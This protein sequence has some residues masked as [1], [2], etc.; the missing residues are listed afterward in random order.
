MT[1][2]RD[3]EERI[4]QVNE[5][6]FS[7]Y[8]LVEKRLHHLHHDLVNSLAKTKPLAPAGASGPNSRYHPASP[9]PCGTWPWPPDV[10]AW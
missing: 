1:P 10:I 9:R 2:P 5:R 8:R 4:R 6:N 7:P 3:T